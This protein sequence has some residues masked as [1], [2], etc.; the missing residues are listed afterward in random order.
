VAKKLFP[1]AAGLKRIANV[2]VLPGVTTVV[3]EGCWITVKRPASL[4]ARFIT[5]PFTASK[6]KFA[7]PEFPIVNVISL[8]L[9]AAKVP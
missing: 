5:W 9:P 6:V 8:V 2:V 3:V 7:S 1:T 4:S